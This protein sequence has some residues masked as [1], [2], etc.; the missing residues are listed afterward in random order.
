MPENPTVD[1]VLSA[2]IEEQEHI[3]NALEIEKVK[4]YEKMELLVSITKE[5][6]SPR[7]TGLR[8][9]HNDQNPKVPH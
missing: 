8:P 7:S 5:A 3:L 1:E 4:A 9:K 6:T 2:R